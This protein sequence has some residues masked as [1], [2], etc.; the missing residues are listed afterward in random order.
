MAIL[1]AMKKWP[2]KRWLLFKG[3]GAIFV[4]FYNLQASEI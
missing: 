2:Y 3:E 1:S 4:I